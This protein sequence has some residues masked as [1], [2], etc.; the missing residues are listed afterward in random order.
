MI[1]N[2][3]T[4]PYIAK[5]AVVAVAALALGAGL[6]TA[7][8]LPQR[9]QDIVADAADRAKLDERLG[10]E[11]PRATP[12]V[13]PDKLRKDL[14]GAPVAATVAALVAASCRHAA[15]AV[16]GRQ[17]AAIARARSR[18]DVLA[19]RARD[20]AGERRRL[21]RET[22]SAR[23]AAKRALDRSSGPAAAS[24]SGVGTGVAGS[25]DW[26]RLDQFRAR[27]DALARR[28]LAREGQ[29]LQVQLSLAGVLAAVDRVAAADAAA[30]RQVAGDAA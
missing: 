21:Q 12:R 27:N 10:L 19:A 5:A 15:A 11:L 18:L 1:V 8:A 29:Q 16:P 20:H 6:A 9:A 30:C 17:T 2:S 13:W 4:I 23:Q 7:G 25:E 26:D 28:E 24:A 22:V 14:R 3:R